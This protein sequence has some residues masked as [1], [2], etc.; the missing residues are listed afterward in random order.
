[1]QILRVC[2]SWGQLRAWVPGKELEKVVDE[3]TKLRPSGFAQQ[4]TIRGGSAQSGTADPFDDSVGAI[5]VPDM[6]TKTGA[7]QVCSAAPAEDRRDSWSAEG[8]WVV[9][10]TH[11]PTVYERAL[12]NMTTEQ[13]R[14]G[15]FPTNMHI[16]LLGDAGWT[17]GIAYPLF[18]KA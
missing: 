3:A 2:R 14:E 13:G 11:R 8:K 12:V 18:A 17:K 10:A 7:G 4:G 6:R 1:M 9:F 15:P 16:T 5:N